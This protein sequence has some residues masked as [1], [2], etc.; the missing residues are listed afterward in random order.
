M[1]GDVA[2]RRRVTIKE[3]VRRLAGA[4][5][6]AEWEAEAAE[7]FVALRVAGVIVTPVMWLRT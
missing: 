1:R 6:S 3:A 7:K 2:T 5:G 4:G